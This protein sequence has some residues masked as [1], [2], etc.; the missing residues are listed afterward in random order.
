MI[1]K[2]WVQENSNRSCFRGGS[3]A[4]VALLPTRQ[5]ASLSSF[6]Q[7]K[8][9]TRGILPDEKLLSLY[10]RLGKLLHSQVLGKLK[11]VRCNMTGRETSV[12]MLPNGHT[13]SLSSFR[14][15]KTCMRGILPDEKLLLLC[16]R[17]GVSFHSQVLG[18]LKLESE[19]GL[20]VKILN[21]K[22]G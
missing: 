21:D 8:T 10:Y 13:V 20:R 11:L 17:T 2:L 6:R 18:K 19:T 5:T 3:E 4:A 15:A 16:Y 14:Q 12:A 1:K 7:A 22:L 9:C